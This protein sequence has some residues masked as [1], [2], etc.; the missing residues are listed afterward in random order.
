MWAFS[1]CGERGYSVAVM[2]GLLLAVVSRVAEHVLWGTRA[3]ATAARRLRCPIVGGNPSG[4]GIELVHL[5]LQ[6][7][8]LITVTPGKHLI[9]KVF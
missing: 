6:G 9:T 5:A 1:G 3:S 8:F 7:R 2:R 4:P